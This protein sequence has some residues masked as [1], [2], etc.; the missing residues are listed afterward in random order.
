MAA[1]VAPAGGTAGPFSAWA[2]AALGRCRARGSRESWVLPFPRLEEQTLHGPPKATPGGVSQAGPG[3][4]QHKRRKATHRKAEMGPEL[5]DSGC[6]GT[7]ALTKPTFPTA[8]W[9]GHACAARSRAQG[10]WSS[11]GHTDPTRQPCNLAA[12]CPWLRTQ[13]CW[14]HSWRTPGRQV[15]DPHTWIHLPKGTSE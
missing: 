8:F 5:P 2:V 13:L 9:P 6:Q 3:P 1:G 12:S 7:V 15:W 10:G 11:C 4:P 14:G